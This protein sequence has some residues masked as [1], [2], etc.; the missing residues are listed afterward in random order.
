MTLHLASAPVSWGIYEF[1]GVAPKYPYARVLDEI[2]ETGYTGIEL[3]PWGYLP[4][5]PNTLGPEL[6]GR[7]LRLLSSYVPVNFADPDALEAGEAFAKGDDA[8]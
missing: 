1:E 7:R 2:A 4:T 5:D 3:D 6:A 8:W